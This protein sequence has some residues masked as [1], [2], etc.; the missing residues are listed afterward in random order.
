MRQVLCLLAIFALSF[1][2]YAGEANHKVA[3]DNLGVSGKDEHLWDSTGDYRYPEKDIALSVCKKNDPAR[4]VAYADDSVVLKYLAVDKNAVYKAE[5]TFLSDLPDRVQQILVDGKVVKGN[6]KLLKNK[7]IKHEII[8]PKDSYQDGEFDLSIEK[9]KGINS[10]VSHVIIKSDVNKQLK[11]KPFLSTITIPRLSP[12]PASVTNVKTL[13]KTLNGTWKFINKAPADISNPASVVSWKDIQVPGEWY[14]QGFVVEKN[15]FAGFSRTFTIPSDWKKQRIKLR[16]D[17][18][19]SECCVYVNGKKV[20]GHIGGFT[21]FELDI[22]DSVLFDKENLISLEVKNESVADTMANG[23]SY[24]CHPLGGI[25]RKVTLFAL[26]QVNISDLAIR[27]TFDK[28][29]TYATLTVLC[30]VTNDSNKA[31]DA[32]KVNLSLKPWKGT[33]GIKLKPTAIEV[34]SLKPGETADLSVSIPVTNPAKWDCENPNLYLLYGNLIVGDKFVEQVTKRFGFRQIETRGNK[35]FVNGKPIKLRGINRH[36]AHPLLGRSLRPGLWRKDAELFRNANVNLIRTCHYP[37]AEELMIA[38]DELGVFVEIEAPHCWSPASGKLFMEPTVRQALE[39]VMFNRSHPSVLM[40]SIANESGWGSNFAKSSK[41]ARDLDPTRPQTFNWMSGNVKTVTEPY[42][43]VADIH[44]PGYS[45]P[46]KSKA[47]GK[48]PV[49]FGEYCHLNAYNRM[50]LATDQSMRATWGEY[51]DKLWTQ[52][53]NTDGCLGGSI[54][55]GIDD[56]FF[57]PNGL[58]LGYG[59]WGPID[60]WRRPK[61]EWWG[62]KKSYSPI[63][64]SKL[65]I[66]NSRLELQIENRQDFSNLNRL[67]ISW[68]IGKET[69]TVTADIKPKSKGELVI[70]L[71]NKI[72]PGSEL[73]LTFNDPRGYVMDSFK[74]PVGQPAVV[75]QPKVKETYSVSNENDKITIKSKNSS[76]VINMKTGLFENSKFSGPYLMILPMNDAGITRMEAKDNPIK[77]DAFTPV[78]KDWKATSVDSKTMN[79]LPVVTVKGMY[80]E[81]AGSFVYKFNANGTFTVDYDFKTT[82]KV[83]PRQLGIVFEL[84]KSYENLSWK[85]KGYWTTYPEWHIARLEGTSNAREGIEGTCVGV[86][87]EPK[88]EWRHDRTKIGSNDFSSTKHNIY[89]ASLT[90]KA[91]HGLKV[92]ANADRHTRTWINGDTIRIL[93]ANYSNGGSERFLRRLSNKDDRPLKKGADVSGSV[94]MKV[95]K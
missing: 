28:S 58:T 60:G 5:L 84:P 30:K 22:T 18:V 29:F 35:L 95:L 34:P 1:N 68:K 93:I 53:Y 24:A 39:M 23:S 11:E 77:Y 80:K 52:M 71:K 82:E 75:E 7:I 92:I 66:M 4:T 33:Q 15:T 51:L 65:K 50:E 79:G 14:M 47:Y 59:T 32:G 44:Y 81:A 56:T 89:N 63:R 2:T 94:V 19:Y 36:E 8:I 57:P 90:N 45:G 43:E 17:A 62:M 3:E 85:R 49:Y 16:F 21:P 61:P 37:P 38:C 26:P 54:W 12:I 73:E 40:W 13:N 46:P 64:V 20:G 69:G 25:S 70:A 74:L 86:K 78:C 41:A 10:V 31:S 9:I 72:V 48:R 6:F 76:Y 83:N 42:C 87:T 67:N 91:G 27:T 55:S 88:H